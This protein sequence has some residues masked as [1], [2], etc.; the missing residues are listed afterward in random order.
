MN[1]PT[2]MGVRQGGHTLE[3]ASAG[4][5]RVVR[6]SNREKRRAVVDSALE[7]FLREGYAA[8]SMDRVADVAGVAKRTIYNHFASKE[9]L[10]LGVIGSLVDDVLEPVDRTLMG[11][12]PASDCLLEFALRYADAMLANN[13]ICLHRLVLGEL[14]RFPS[15]GEAFVQGYRQAKSGVARMMERLELRGE[16]QIDDL[17]RAA[18]V[19]WQITVAPIQRELLFRL[20]LRKE[21]IPVVER[22]RASVGAF[23]KIYGAPDRGSDARESD[24]VTENSGSNYTDKCNYID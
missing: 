15:L 5:P 6:R 21:D 8:A 19:F 20:E 23:L 1:N 13:R 9:D 7:V 12:R 2:Q 4:E 10:F 16:I 18:D 22:L 14:S 24:R 17:D 3:N 11:A